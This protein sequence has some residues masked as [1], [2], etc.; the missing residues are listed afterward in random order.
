MGAI[1]DT[2]RSLDKPVVDH[3]VTL[4]LKTSTLTVD[5]C[6][7]ARTCMSIY[8]LSDAERI[9]QCCRGAAEQAQHNPSETRNEAVGFRTSR[10]HQV[11]LARAP[12][13]RANGRGQYRAGLANLGNPLNEEHL[14]NILAAVTHHLNVAQ[15]TIDVLS[16]I[17]HHLPEQTT[18]EVFTPLQRT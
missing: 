2:N 14:A 18:I 11:E 17:I 16:S 1:D 6:A 7:S 3:V 9:S 8:T 15:A 13:H 10:H 5:V 4:L 12:T